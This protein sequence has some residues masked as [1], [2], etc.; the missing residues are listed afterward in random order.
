MTRSGSAHSSTCRGCM[1]VRPGAGSWAK[2][3]P[4]GNHGSPKQA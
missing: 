2:S 1:V 4:S 3:I